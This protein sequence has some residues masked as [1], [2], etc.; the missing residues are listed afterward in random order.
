MALLSPTAAERIVSLL[1]YATE[2]IAALGCGE[3]LVGRSHEC[4]F[5]GSVHALPVCSQSRIET[6]G[7]SRDV[8]DFVKQAL[9]QGLSIFQVDVPRLEQLKPDLIIT[10]TQC[11]VCAVS[12]ADVET[13]LHN[14]ISSRPRL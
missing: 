10:Q 7:S 13:A 1:P 2:I 14:A 8:D 9:E 11:A 5:P 6:C 3:R 12:L 4:D